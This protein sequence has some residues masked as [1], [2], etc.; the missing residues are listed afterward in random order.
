MLEWDNTVN[1]TLYASGSWIGDSP[2]WIIQ[3]ISPLPNRPINTTNFN[4]FNNTKRNRILDTCKRIIKFLSGGIIAGRMS[5]DHERPSASD[6]LRRR[7]LQIME[8]A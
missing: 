1:A 5:Q 6:I 7:G 2:L 8:N 4:N 3:V